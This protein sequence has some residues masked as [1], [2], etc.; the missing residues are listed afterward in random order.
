MKRKIAL[1]LAGVVMLCTLAIAQDTLPPFSGAWK[2][3]LKRSKVEA[4]NPPSASTATIRYDGK[5]WNFSRTHQFPD[6]PADTWST[7]VPVDARE[8]QI[9]HEP[10]LTISTRVTRE[11]NEVVLR[12]TYVADSGEKATNTVHYRLEDAN[13]TLIE[14]EQETTPEGTEHN[15]WMLTR[16]DK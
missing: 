11:G 9:S 6:K 5:V 13:Q 16:V 1:P 4:K 2:L 12:E 14:D 8:P 7:S 10:S 3:D 15:L